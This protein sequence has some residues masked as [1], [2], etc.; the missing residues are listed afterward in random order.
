MSITT[1]AA[2]I[3]TILAVAGFAVCIYVYLRDKSLEAIRN[4]VYSLF[5]KAEHRYL[6][7]GAGKQK[8]KYVVQ[9]ARSLLPGWLQFF[10]SDEL[11]MKVIDGWFQAVK[12]LLDDGK[13][14]GSCT[15]TAER[16]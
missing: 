13:V 2:I 5:L 14:N 9:K 16:E 11:L 3:V 4:D 8:L 1:I 15:D 10:I 6:E 12:D 7:T